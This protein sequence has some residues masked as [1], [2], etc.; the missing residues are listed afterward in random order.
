MAKNSAP[1]RPTNY[2]V[3]AEV[4]PPAQAPGLLGDVELLVEAHEQAEADLRVVTRGRDSD[5]AAVAQKWA[6][7]VNKALTTAETA[8]KQIDAKYEHIGRAAIFDFKA[9]SLSDEELIYRVG[10]L[11]SREENGN[12]KTL[13]TARAIRTVNRFNSLLPGTPVLAYHKPDH[14][15]YTE[16]Y[17]SNSPN[18]P[19]ISLGIGGILLEK[20]TLS[21]PA[22]PAWWELNPIL[23]LTF[24]GGGQFS[25]AWS[26][27]RAI[28]A[29]VN[30]VAAA[31]AKENAFPSRSQEMTNAKVQTV[32]TGL[33]KLAPL[34]LELDSLNVLRK[35]VLNEIP[36][37]L[38]EQ[39]ES[40]NSEGLHAT[41]S[42]VRLVGGNK[43]LGQVLKSLIDVL[44][45]DVLI[46]ELA[47]VFETDYNGAKDDNHQ[48][49]LSKAAA[50]IGRL[51]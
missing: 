50:V 29:D 20:A 3:T 30:D 40:T 7:P 27:Q 4:E 22:E 9:G 45:E 13:D 16:N 43:S 37:R 48:L 42:Q 21:L 26:N 24:E 49:A 51:A 38:P 23:N 10:L 6:R 12:A 31:W 1:E 39:V 25:S 44:P 17:Y 32:L 41:L 33:A 35:A 47:E 11:T 8:Q 2:P 18:E 19:K 46:K 36:C 34:K 5:I 28:G 15:A 14:P